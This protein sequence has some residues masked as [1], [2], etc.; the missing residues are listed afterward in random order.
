MPRFVDYSG[1][2]FP[3]QLGEIMAMLWHAFGRLPPDSLLAAQH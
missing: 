2:M 3:L 1:V